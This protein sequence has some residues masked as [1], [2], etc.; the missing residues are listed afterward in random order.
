VRSKRLLL[1]YLAVMGLLLLAGLLWP[2][3]FTA[4]LARP[5]FYLHAKFVHV[6]FV[7]LLFGNAVIGTMWEIRSVMSG[8][9]DIV[10]YTYA[11]V[12]W[13][14]AVF[15][16]PLIIVSVVSGIML[17]T[18]LGGVFRIGW[19]TVGFSLFLLTGLVWVLA[20]IPNQYR[21]NR[22]LDASNGGAGGFSP[23]LKVLLRR[24]MAVNAFGILPLLIV[25][26]LMVHKPQ[27]PKLT[28]WLNRSHADVPR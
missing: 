8:R 23:E 20:D 19:V 21:L 7:T 27:M 14:D 12:S 22:L 5:Q 25:F 1:F 10:R 24:R 17:A 28:A 11:T 6:L 15:T 9:T 3:H 26:Y 16:A 13:L 2:D 4:A 18:I